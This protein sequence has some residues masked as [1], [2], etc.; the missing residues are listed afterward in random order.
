LRHP[1]G[2]V[3]DWSDQTPIRIAQS[4]VTKLAAGVIADGLLYGNPDQFAVQSLAAAVTI[5]F[6][7]SEHGERA[8][9]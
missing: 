2:L 3:A 9:A 6:A 7:L 4:G 5:G 8:Y 1:D